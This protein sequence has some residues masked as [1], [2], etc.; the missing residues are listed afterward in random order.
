VPLLASTSFV[1]KTV[2]TPFNES[3]GR[4]INSSMGTRPARSTG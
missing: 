4:L 2:L 1:L 3:A